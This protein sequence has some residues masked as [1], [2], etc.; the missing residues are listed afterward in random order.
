MV[1]VGEMPPMLRTA[2]PCA[3][4]DGLAAA[5][6]LCLRERL[7][8]EH[9]QPAGKAGGQSWEQP[10]ESGSVLAPTLRT[11]RHCG[12]WERMVLSA[13]SSPAGGP[14]SCSG[15]LSCHMV[16]EVSLGM[17]HPAQMGEGGTSG[18]LFP[19]LS[20]LPPGWWEQGHSA[21]WSLFAVGGLQGGSEEK[22]CWVRAPVLC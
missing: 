22:A 12:H 11:G 18:F 4:E 10:V 5:A 15:S 17:A 21:T 7:R 2:H 19:Q 1:N 3:C 20:S 6:S 14:V 9:A 8:T 13:L 16:T